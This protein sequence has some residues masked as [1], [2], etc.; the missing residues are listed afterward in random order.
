LTDK[1]A[2]K[3][4]KYKSLKDSPF[5]FTP[6]DITLKDDA[7]HDSTAPRFTEW[8]YFDAKFGNGYSIQLNVR[9]LS[10]I[11][12]RF[13]LIYKRLD[14][15]KDG[16][17]IKHY[18]KRYGLKDFDVSKEIPSV[19]LDGTEVIKGYIDKK[20][21][22]L[23]Y[24][25]SFEIDNTSANLQFKS[26]TKGWKGNNPGGDGWA[27]ILPRAE[28]EGILK[29]ND[30]EIQV[31]GIGYHDHNWDLRYSAAKNNHGWFW[32]K[33]YSK[34]FTVIWAT[35]YKDK[36]TGQPLLI[37]NKNNNGYIN[38]KPNEINFIGDKLSLKNK[39]MIP[40]HFIIE[41]DNGKEKI[42]FSMDA[43][44]FHHDKVMFS[45]HYWRYHMMCNG[46]ITVD[47][48]TETIKDTQIAEF[49]RFQ[50]R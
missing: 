19:K 17:L 42:K 1:K 38:F 24:D 48:K 49:L 6:Q 14:L 25:V 40:H 43:E 11:K 13:A 30:K 15:Y 12:N 37:I 3:E 31:K 46:T 23:I 18:R 2:E 35:I 29:L 47:N 44:N 10:V 22:K 7:F 16:H 36:N 28:V 21:G 20:T 39:K 26:L 41:A 8:W 34:N 33:I 4:F 27:V 45:Y 32:S 5:R 9:L 50:D